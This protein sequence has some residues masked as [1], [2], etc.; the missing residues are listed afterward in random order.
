MKVLSDLTKSFQRDQ[1][2]IANLLVY[3]EAGISQLDVLWPQR[4]PRYQA[5]VLQ[6]GTKKNPKLR[7][8]PPQFHIGCFCCFQPKIGPSF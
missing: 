6:C 5:G 8:N 4:D 1:F 2:C 3:L 7:A